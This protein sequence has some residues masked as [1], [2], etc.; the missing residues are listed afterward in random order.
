MQFSFTEEQRM[1]QRSLHEMLDKVAPS[2]VI[3]ELDEKEEFPTEIVKKMAEFGLYG[4]GVPE[5]YGGSGGGLAEMAIVMEE[6]AYHGAC[7]L[8]VYAPTVGFCRQAILSFGSEEH[9][10]EFLPQIASGKLRMAMGLSEP[11]HGSDLV[12][13]ETT[14]DL[15]GDEYVIRGNKIFTTGADNAQ[16][17]FTMV[18]TDKSVSPS[19]GISVL[20]TP[21]N[22]PGISIR[23]LKKLG[24][25]AV[26]TCEVAFDDVRVP[27]ANLLYELN[28]GWKI[29]MEHLDE[30]R[31]LM[32]AQC[33][34]TARG[35][36]ECA[37]R[38]AKEREQF[39]QP[40][41][42][43]QTI[44][45]MLADM[46][47]DVEAIR[48]MTYNNIYRKTNGLPCTKEASMARVFCSEAAMRTAHKAVQIH[49]GYG[50]MMEYDAQRY[51]REAK[52][53]EIAGGTNQIQREVI[54]RELGL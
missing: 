14:A 9:K 2:S 52:L 28:K 42:K 10:R 24:G 16:Y 27:K 8:Y 11:D 34:G 7:L 38:Y 36:F 18:R 41:G 30:E 12:T 47:I 25:Q 51:F 44:A 48:L 54:A 46:A 43:F 53:W 4:V 22:S 33:L 21:T 32:G 13:L 3:Q 17:I 50:Y 40:I 5:E 19:R 15:D 23:P 49:G 39:G 37:L 20:L 29:V 6:L 45:H 1:F 26:H 35:A 31:I